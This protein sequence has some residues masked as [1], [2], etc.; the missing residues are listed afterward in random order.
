MA[1][2]IKVLNALTPGVM[3]LTTNSSTSIYS[4]VSP[5]SALISGVAIFNNSTTSLTVSLLRGTVPIHKT[6]TLGA[7]ASAFMSDVVELAAAEGL[8]AQASATPTGGGA[9]ITVLLFGIE[10][11]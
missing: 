4:P 8:S 1:T 9:N 7:S 10:R 6:A 2:N 11:D 5:K 3:L